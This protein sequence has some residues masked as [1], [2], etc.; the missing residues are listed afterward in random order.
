M[1]PKQAIE[2]QTK[3]WTQQQK[4]S[5]QTIQRL[6]DI[7]DNFTSYLNA[8]EVA[9]LADLTTRVCEAFITA[10]DTDGQPTSIHVQHQR[11]WVINS[12][13]TAIQANTNNPAA[14]VTIAKR[15]DGIVRPL[16]ND[17]IQLARTAGTK[18]GQKYWRRYAAWALAETT[19]ATSEIPQITPA[20]IHDDTLELPGTARLNPRTVPIQPWAKQILEQAIAHQPDTT[21]PLTYT[22][23]S[24]PDRPSPQA[25]T[26]RLI[27]TILDDTY[28][29]TL[30]GV[31]PASI[32]N[33]RGRH[34]YDQ[35][36]SLIEVA[37]LL[38]HPN[39]D[40][41]AAAIGLKK[42]IH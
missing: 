4:Y 39:L 10:P 20:N 37:E 25:A 8:L 18:N 42:A 38:G 32:R 14:Q 23:N 30:P 1:D 21:K 27:Y 24:P 31:K 7:S 40:R 41:T 17:E 28:L 15:P 2:N 5:A 36:A 26:C 12:Y 34:D 16:T 11:R 6:I 9:D 35:G 29:N 33:W 19:A 3:N 22:G 13:L